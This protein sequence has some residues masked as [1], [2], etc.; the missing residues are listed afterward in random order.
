MV[1]S[2][3]IWKWKIGLYWQVPILLW[4]AFLQKKDVL[5]RSRVV[6]AVITGRLL[7][8]TVWTYR[9]KIVCSLSSGYFDWKDFLT[10]QGVADHVMQL[11]KWNWKISGLWLALKL[12][13]IGNIANALYWTT[14]FKILRNLKRTRPYSTY[15]IITTIMIN[16]G[17]FYLHELFWMLQ[18]SAIYCFNP[19]LR[20]CFVRNWVLLYI[21]E[22]ENRSA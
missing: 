10:E 15:I 21:N 2:I 16:I 4:L 11:L 9:R 22:N 13:V 20:L 18:W 6:L 14:P 12:F 19:K 3:K 7:V 8:T 1:R 5:W 17:T